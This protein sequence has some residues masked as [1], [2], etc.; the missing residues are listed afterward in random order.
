MNTPVFNPIDFRLL[1]KAAPRYSNKMPE[2][3]ALPR[4]ECPLMTE[5]HNTHATGLGASIGAGCYRSLAHIRETE[6][7][8]N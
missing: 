7:L 2:R 8:W 4:N 5:A 3:T 6:N 1:R